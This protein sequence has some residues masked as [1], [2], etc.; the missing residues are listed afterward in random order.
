MRPD[1]YAI[2][3]EK[4]HLWPVAA[5]MRPIDRKE[6]WASDRRTPFE[7]LSVS[8]S[9]SRRAWTAM[10]G[11]VPFAVFGVGQS[12]VP[13]LGIPWLLS[14]PIIEKARIPF[15]RQSRRFVDEMQRGFRVLE[16]YVSAE[17]TL[18]LK[19]LEFCG[20]T[21]GGECERNG[22]IFHKFWRESNV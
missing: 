11:E 10:A 3:A 16:N 20:F 17:N 7:A 19:W 5:N 1:Y 18:S 14:T 12:L 21:I 4:K 22:H 6:V 2:A 9:N 13:W 8:L 15:L